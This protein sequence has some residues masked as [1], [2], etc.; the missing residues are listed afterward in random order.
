M[1]DPKPP[2]LA[3]KVRER[4]S[5]IEA[6]RLEYESLAD[7][8]EKA[9]RELATIRSAFPLAARLMTAEE[10]SADWRRQ[11]AEKLSAE[12]ERDALRAEL[13]KFRDALTWCS[14]SAD[15]G[16][17]GAAREGWLSLCEPLLAGPPRGETAGGE[18]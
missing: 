6:A 4:M 16:H 2:T 10:I 15:F 5:E 3:E 12:A 1:S 9:E 14:G 13:A 17:G 7:R 18:E 8:A 11:H